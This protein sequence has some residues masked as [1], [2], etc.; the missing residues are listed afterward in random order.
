M[1]EA[2]RK[3]RDVT[4]YLTHQ[5]NAQANG[6]GKWVQDIQCRCD[7]FCEVVIAVGIHRMQ[8][9]ALEGR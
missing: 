4:E 2:D 3:F 8:G 5:P 1:Q 9:L 7:P 6:L